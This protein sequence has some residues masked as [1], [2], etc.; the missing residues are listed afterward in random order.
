MLVGAA[1][2]EQPEPSTGERYIDS[3]PWEMAWRA[4]LDHPGLSISS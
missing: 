1:V 4:A 2:Y 3:F